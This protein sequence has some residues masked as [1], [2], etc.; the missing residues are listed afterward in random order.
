[1]N[2]NR[3]RKERK[4]Y[5]KRRTN[6][7]RGAAAE[8]NREMQSDDDGLCDDGDTGTTA[9]DE[10]QRAVPQT[11]GAQDPISQRWKK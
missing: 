8:G 3:K 6:V 10:G 7:Q 4:A 11:E 5:D 1:M 9:E 2:E